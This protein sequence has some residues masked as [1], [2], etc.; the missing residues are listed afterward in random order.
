V[1][2]L[3]TRSITRLRPSASGFDADGD[4]VTATTT[5]TEITGVLLAPRTDLG[6]LGEV[7][8]RGRNGVVVGFTAYFRPGSD[9]TRFDLFEIDGAKWKVTGEPGPWV[10]HMVGGIEVALER[11][12]G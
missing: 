5:A 10:G 7:N 4:P 6:S 3:R 1:T 8:G 12:E 2:L 9:V 11:A